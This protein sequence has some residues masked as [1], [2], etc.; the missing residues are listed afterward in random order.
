M[1]K[2]SPVPH[3]GINHGENRMATEAE[4]VQAHGGRDAT[5][6]HRHAALA[7]P[8]AVG[9]A[10]PEHG[11]DE[12]GGRQDAAQGDVRQEVEAPEPRRGQHE[13]R[14]QQH[15]PLPRP[16]G[17]PVEGGE[18]ARVREQLLQV[19]PLQD[20]EVDGDEVELEIHE[21]GDGDPALPAE[22]QLADVRVGLDEGA[23]VDASL[24]EDPRVEAD[25]CYGYEDC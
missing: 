14:E 15:E 16:A 5:P 12:D 4:R 3:A 21:G 1:W 19:V 11:R 7:E 8:D 23:G 25:R 22:R 9:G 13:Q 6:P 2:H 10:D 24:Q 17:D 18:E 20:E